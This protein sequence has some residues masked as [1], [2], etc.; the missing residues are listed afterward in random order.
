[1]PPEGTSQTNHDSRGVLVKLLKRLED[2]G[3]NVFT[4]T[5]MEF[6][7]L[8]RG[9]REPPFSEP[10]Y[11]S[12]LSFSSQEDILFYIES[13]MRS[14]G[15]DIET[16]HTE[17]AVG[18]FEF[19]IK[20]AEGIKALDN[21]FLFKTY[22][23][24][25]ARKKGMLVSFVT[26]GQKIGSTI[27]INISLWDKQGNGILFNESQ[28]NHLSRIALHWIAGLVIHTS[29]LTALCAPT[30]NCYRRLNKPKVADWGLDNRRVCYRV[31]NNGERAT[32]IE[33]RIPSALANPYLAM[34]ATL[35]AGLDGIENQLE[36]PPLED[37]EAKPIPANLSEALI[38]LE[39]DEV[40][41]NSLGGDLIS[42][43][44][45]IKRECELAKLANHDVK[46]DDA[47]ELL[48]ERLFYERL[49]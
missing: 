38:A 30:V 29:A 22:V 21:V 36:C 16:M 5:E 43:F 14:S 34:A 4:G 8:Q 42:A 2:L 28:E 3:I 7:M 18:M 39:K 49:M 27:D 46:S 15:I 44:I 25:L 41:K 24:E 31:R 37:K 12:Q 19:T 9:S 40:I 13:N 48:A 17:A 23:K 6:L 32:Y 1:M 11:C 20:P 33:N 35:A 26:D 47:D 10:D 45:D